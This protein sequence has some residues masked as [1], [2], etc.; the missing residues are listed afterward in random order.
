MDK[1][2]ELYR[3]ATEDSNREL[4]L[5]IEKSKYREWEVKV[6]ELGYDRPFIDVRGGYKEVFI[7]AYRKLF[8]YLVFDNKKYVT[9]EEIL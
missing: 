5:K 1:F 6:Y 9:R 4:T 7:K 2:I 3:C 8:E